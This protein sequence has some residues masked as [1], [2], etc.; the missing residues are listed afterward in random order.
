MGISMKLVNGVK[1]I[2]MGEKNDVTVYA[3]SNFMA[4]SL[5]EED[6]EFTTPEFIIKCDS[7]VYPMTNFEQYICNEASRWFN[8]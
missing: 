1:T 5:G 6:L 3:T 4:L 7:G 2:F 8:N